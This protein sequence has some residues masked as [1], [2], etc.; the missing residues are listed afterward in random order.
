MRQWGDSGATVGRQWGDSG[1]TVGRV[2][3]IAERRPMRP[4]AADKTS[5]GLESRS[6]ALSPISVVL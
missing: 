4:E 6:G 5:A 3:D 2:A 1:A